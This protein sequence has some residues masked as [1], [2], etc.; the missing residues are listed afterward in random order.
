[1][2]NAADC[3]G[4][5][6]GSATE[7]R[8]C[9]ETNAGSFYGGTLTN[10]NLTGLSW[11]A[12]S[13]SNS[14]R[15]QAN[16]Q[17]I[18]ILRFNFNSGAATPAG[19]TSG[20]TYSVSY[21]SAK[22][23]LFII[24]GGTKSMEIPT[25][26]VNF[27]TGDDSK[28]ELQLNLSQATGDFAFKGNIDIKAGKGWDSPGNGA[29]AFVGEF[30]SNVEGNITT[31]RANG[32][33]GNANGHRTTL[34]FTNNASLKGNLHTG[35]GVTTATFKNGS[36]TGNIS[37]E[38]ISTLSNATNTI[39]FKSADASLTGNITASQAARVGIKSINNIVFVQGG[40]IKGNLLVTAGNNQVAF[41]G[42]TSA[43]ID[44]NITSEFDMR[45]Y[46]GQHHKSVT[47]IV[48]Q[49]S[50]TNTITGAITTKTAN[51]TITMGGTT[52]TITGNIDSGSRQSPIQLD[53]SKHQSFGNTITMTADNSTITGNLSANEGKNTITFG[54]NTQAINT[55]T[56]TGNINANPN[57]YGF[58]AGRNILNFYATTATITGNIDA[59][60]STNEITFYQADST[61][62]INGNITNNAGTNTITAA[63]GTLK[64]GSEN[65]RASI[66][67]SGGGKAT[68]T[69]TAKKLDLN[70]SSISVAGNSNSNNTNNITGD[71]GSITAENITASSGANTNNITLGAS[72][73]LTVTTMQASGG[74][75]NTITLK[76]A[77]STFTSNG[78]ITTNAGTNTI[79]VDGGSV[80]MNSSSGEIKVD[81]GGTAT[82]TITAKKLDLNLSSI[83]T[84]G[85]NN[86]KN[87]NNI[88]GEGTITA[89]TITA[90]AGANNIT[91]GASSTLTATTMQASGGTSTI[92]AKDS[93]KLDIATLE[94]S[95]GSNNINL[96]GVSSLASS[97]SITA[98]GGANTITIA[99][100]AHSTL[101]IENLKADS[102]T[103]SILLDNAKLNLDIKNAE[104]TSGT[105]QITLKGESKLFNQSAKLALDKLIFEDARFYPED[106][107]KDM[108][109]QKST[110]MDLASLPRD[111]SKAY[112][113]L[114]IGSKGTQGNPTGGLQGE[115]GLFRVL[116]GKSDSATGHTLGGVTASDGKDTANTY[117]YAYSDR[118]IVYNVL[119]ANGNTSTT[120]ID[121]YLQIVPEANMDLNGVKYNDEGGTEIEGNVA[122]FTTRN[123]ANNNP[124]VTLNS[125]K[126][127]LVGYDIVGAELTKGIQTDENGR[128]KDANGGVVT[129]KSYTT[130]FIKSMD[131]QGASKANQLSAITA[132]SNNYMLYLAN[133]NSLNKRMGELR[134][135]SAS[136]GA[137]LRIFNGMQSTSFTEMLDS[138]AI[139]TTIQAGYDYTFGFKG[140]SNYLGFALSYA[141]SMSKL[142]EKSGA[143]IDINN[144]SKSITGMNSNAFEFAI[145]NAYVQDGAS[146]ATGFKNGLYSDS[147]AKFSY[148]MSNLDVTGENKLNTSNFA[149]TFSQ[150]LG[151]RFLLGNDREF[152]IDPQAE[153]TLGYLNQSNL[154]RVLGKA[155]LK[156]SQD[157]IFTLRSRVGS[158]FGYKFDKFTQNKG[159]NSSLY[160]GTYFVSD[161]IAGGDI[162]MQS[163]LSQ[164][165]FKALE[166]TARF[167]LN[168]GTNF[169]IKDN[170]RIYF[171]FERSFGGKIT[172]DYQLNLGV[173]YSFGTSK[174]TPYT[175]TT[176]EAPKDSNTLKEVEPTKG[177][178]IEL[179]EKEDK[180]LSSKELKTLQNLKEELRI[181][182]KTQNNK[183]LKTYLAGPFKDESKAKEAKTKLEGVIK[184]LKGKGSVVEVE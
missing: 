71:S 128:T 108:E 134:E 66:T 58:A 2:A 21:G 78:S 57:G 4:V 56:L 88:T 28:R 124:L 26:E 167:V 161:V 77:D 55:A 68:N 118:V 180:K 148:I 27:G 52:A 89:A 33:S 34:T 119:D 74:S 132:L 83:S 29:S 80:I 130:Y 135:N 152:Y 51:N 170:T 61:S 113:L 10:A 109:A 73:T 106:F 62:T 49:S 178:Y 24:D 47:T 176:Q 163:N 67:A 8:L 100:G 115:S 143:L 111:D 166:S 15:P 117:G 146:K 91:L 44:G 114:E 35:S 70:L 17:D 23:Q 107:A 86:S 59:A 181:Q 37:A 81:G 144:Q 104:S 145:Y 177:Y 101:S 172:T 133:L 165:S 138:R 6:G 53:N 183:T 13:S 121:E 139:Y 179:L 75:T 16:S 127:S 123:D 156:A 18:S 31:A 93:T 12:G 64:I 131:N 40:T 95:S 110:T 43:T 50:G 5:S 79:K 116:V 92:T 41:G 30:G 82:N 14:V 164:A 20:T 125:T 182:T 102:G 99:Q 154:T 87:T 160:L 155:F 169:K 60:S 76:G 142:N 54:S 149:F 175:E 11:A 9:Y 162:F 159:F 46:G 147:I 151:Y 122:V 153:I 84:T 42:T 22:K 129:N 141:N 32:N 39:I 96:E 97:T 45:S 94:A 98:S 19:T 126:Q 174:Y 168:L 136:Q 112:R 173:R 105:N 69:I 171:D 48:M 90:S 120:P 157:S 1:M 7:P 158:S 85:N 72:S 3:S 38:G 25:L 65:S 36:M 184:E 63:T 140:A 137:W 103:N 150:E